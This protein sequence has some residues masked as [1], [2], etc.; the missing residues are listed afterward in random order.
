MTRWGIPPPPKF[1]APPVTNICNTASPHWRG[2]LKP[3]SR[4][5]VPAN[6][7]SNIRIEKYAEVAGRGPIKLARQ[8][9]SANSSRADCWSAGAHW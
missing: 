4:C 8:K 6:S 3:E 2:W 1:G 7:F 9:C 5:L